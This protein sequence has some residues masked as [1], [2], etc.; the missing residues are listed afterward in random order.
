MTAVSRNSNIE[1]LRL[2][3]MFM[4]VLLHFNNAAMGGAFV[5]VKDKVVDNFVLHI[6]ESL[7]ICAVNGFMIISGY[8]LYTNKKVNF[9]KV[10]DI[11]L[12]VIFYRIFDY[13]MQILFFDVSFSIKCFLSRF[14]PE[15][16]FAI[17]Y[18]VCY[19][20]SPY[21]AWLW[22][23]MGN[24][25]ANFFIVLLLAIFIIIPTGLDLAVDLHILN[26]ASTLSPIAIMGNG[27]GYTV[28]Q[29]LVMLSLGMWIRKRQLNISTSLL[30][31]IYIISSLI[32]TVCIAKMPSLYNYC[33]IFTVITAVCIFL[34][35]SK[36]KFKNQVI[37]FCAKSSFAIFCIHTGEF[38]NRIWRNIITEKFFANGVFQTIFWML[39]CVGLMFLFCLL[40]SIVMR[41]IFG[42]LKSFFVGI[43]PVYVSDWK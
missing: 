18:V 32:M 28:I 30:I 39:I 34:L 27:A 40:I 37:N 10:I 7:S 1:L 17:F 25:M 43:F 4:V 12:I 14:L 15:N 29:F 3:L 21:I 19:M 2:V 36:I 42:K 5:Y 31:V 6:F 26:N 35:F 20:L 11:L 23:E 33:S 9:G 24:S 38:A 13:I 41:L 16:Y 22:N 8:F